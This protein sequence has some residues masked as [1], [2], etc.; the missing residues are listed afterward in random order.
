M[1]ERCTGILV[2]VHW[3]AIAAF[4]TV[5]IGFAFVCVCVCVCVC[6]TLHSLAME[7]DTYTPSKMP[8]MFFQ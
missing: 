4:H 3:V 1:P 6:Y 7:T 2:L 5:S 8:Q